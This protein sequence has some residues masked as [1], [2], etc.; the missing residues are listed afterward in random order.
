MIFAS[1]GV[2]GAGL[3]ISGEKA[4][5]ALVRRAL[6]RASRQNR[7]GFEPGRSRH[8]PPSRDRRRWQ[9][10]APAIGRPGADAGRG[11]LAGAAAPARTRHLPAR[12]V[13]GAHSPAASVTSPICCGRAWWRWLYPA[14]HAEALRRRPPAFWRVPD[15]IAHIEYLLRGLPEGGPLAVFLPEIAGESRDRPLLLSGGGVQHAD[16]EPG[17]GA[18]WGVGVGPGRGVAADP[19]RVPRLARSS[20]FWGNSLSSQLRQHWGSAARH[21]VQ[22]RA[23]QSCE[24]LARWAERHGNMPPVKNAGG[25]PGQWP[26]GPRQA[27]LLGRLRNAVS[28]Q[29]TDPGSI[30]LAHLAPRGTDRKLAET[31]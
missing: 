3:G 11:G 24:A 13:G 2:R 10:M 22:A 4:Y 7:L 15:A 8:R 28:T 17:A 9:S 1:L 14:Q 23:H 30:E 16:C 29:W 6:I 21:D 19:G 5:R 26:Q 25:R 27:A 31:A 20:G 18:G 12:R